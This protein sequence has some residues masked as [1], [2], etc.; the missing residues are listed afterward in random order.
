MLPANTLRESEV[1]YVV[2]LTTVA[3]SSLRKALR[4][5]GLD[6]HTL[7]K[8]PEVAQDRFSEDAL[9]R[10]TYRANRNAA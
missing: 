6:L 7:W 10:N 1:S 4:F 9:Y 3:L 8:G 2:G 5:V